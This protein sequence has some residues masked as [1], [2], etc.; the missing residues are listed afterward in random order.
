MAKKDAG[1]VRAEGPSVSQ[2]SE[3]MKRARHDVRGKLGVI[4]GSLTTALD[5]DLPLT[6]EQ[7]LE[8]V[9]IAKDGLGELGAAIQAYLEAL[10]SAKGEIRLPE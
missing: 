6:P 9:S 1:A 2:T 5:A 8:L 7:R 10:T 4:Q 3:Q